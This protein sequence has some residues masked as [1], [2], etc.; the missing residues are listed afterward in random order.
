MLTTAV[1]FATGLALVSPELDEQLST[2]RA[3]RLIP[4]D[5]VLDEQFDAGLLAELVE[6]MPK[7]QKQAEVARI[8]REFNAGSQADLLDYLAA[9]EAEGSVRDVTSL[10]LVNMVY[11]EATPAVIRAVER[12]AEVD[13]VDNDLK[14][15]PGLLPAVARS[16]ATDFGGE[17]ITYGV[18][19]INAPAVW[20]LGYT[21]QGV[22]VGDIDTGCNY[23]HHDLADHMWTDAN[24]PHHGWDFL[25]DDDDPMDTSGHGTHTCGTVASDGTAGT[26]CGVAPDAMIMS[27]RVRTVADT[28]GENQIWQAMEF[29]VSPPLSPT[30]GG[31]VITMSL[32]Y[33]QSWDP[34][35]ATWR[36]GCNNV[37]AAGV[38]MI[39]AAGNE[40][41]L[42]PP[43]SC[44][45]PGDV[46]PPWWNPENTGTGTLSNV[47]SIGATD[48]NDQYASFSSRGPVQWANV[49]GFNDYAYPPG[50]SKPDVSAPG[51][52]TKSCHYSNNTG[53]QE[54]SGTSMA[55]PHTAGTVA[56]MLSKNPNLSPAVI[57]SI[58]EM[59]AV[60]LGPTGKD[61]DY[62]A[63]RIDALAAVNYVTGSG[64]PSLVMQGHAVVDPPPGGNNN[65]RVDPGETAE[66]E[67]TLR[68]TGGANATSVAGTLVSGDGRLVVSDANGSWGDIPTGGSAVNTADRF[69]VQADGGI[70]PGTSIPC[71]LHVTA[72]SADYENTFVFSLTIG[73]PPT[74]GSAMLDHDTGY[75][76]L[77]V[78]CFGS[79]GYDDPS[80]AGSGFCYP[81][82]A[83]SALYYAGFAVGNGPSYV[84]DR[85]Y[86]SPASG[87]PETDLVIV[88]SLRP[89]AGSPVADEHFLGSYSDAGHSAPKGL[90]VT[91]NSYQMADPG[92]DDFVV[93]VFDIENLGASQVDGLYAGIFGDFDIGSSTS[94][95]CTSD[96]SRRLMYMRQETTANPTVGVKILWPHS[97]ANLSAIDHDIYVYPDSCVTDNQK[98]RWLDG[99]L[100]QRNS[101]RTDDW[102]TLN[103][104]GPFNLP[105]GAMYRFAAA[106]VG[107]TSEAEALTHADSAQSWFDNNVGILEGPV[108]RREVARRLEVRPNP[109]TSGTRI[110][111]TVS[112]PGRVR[113]TAF[114]ITGRNRTVLLDDEVTAGR[115]ELRWQPSE[116]AGGIYF[117]RF[118][119]PD[120]VETERLLLTR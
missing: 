75:C 85:F 108:E 32:G 44:R 63:G 52:D 53:Y 73:Q 49:S 33:L 100:V 18:D 90:K 116:L 86:G 71:T 104:V 26:Q 36:T 83:A 37:G 102:S 110:G 45:C 112:R 88:D 29:V 91:Q 31:D 120:G 62:G 22:V 60:D 38:A 21:G 8:L 10:W 115:G 17:E 77:T 46:P 72:D 103:S 59:T 11:C 57:D 105:V 109:F 54:M 12:R 34:R 1:L 67:M 113:I 70:T 61:N 76:K 98:S 99:T 50:L 82:T 80:D 64:G 6:G 48:Q 7:R 51:V 81:K 97:F 43:N 9:R 27:C 65:G 2:A 42:S 20:A 55:T 89:V 56:L 35:R 47:I 4:V 79:I 68:N 69:E 111:Y 25:D 118:E 66:L 40:R 58:L 14:Y 119:S 95:T 28:L 13:Y 5:I 87:G 16:D 3:D 15:S 24:Y 92:Y 117:V 74:P 114:D 30:N 78:S 107:G 19:R 101:T 23:N 93:M 84:A 106:F 96:E 94:N 41:Y 39:V